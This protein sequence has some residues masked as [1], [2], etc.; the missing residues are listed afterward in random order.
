MNEAL[1]PRMTVSQFKVACTFFRRWP[2]NTL[3]GFASI[4]IA[5]IGV[6]IHDVAVHQKGSARWAQPPAR[7]QVLDG[8]LVK[9]DESKILYAKIM[10]FDDR[11]AFSTAVIKAVLEH[12]PDAFEAGDQG[13]P[14]KAREA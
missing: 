12:A 1:R 6:T 5:E 14:K 3:R 13:L 8:I 9:D 7:P 11:S 10:D 2:K 4:K